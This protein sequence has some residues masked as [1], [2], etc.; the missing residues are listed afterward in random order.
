VQHRGAAER[1]PERLVGT[2]ADP[3]EVVG[4]QRVGE[5]VRPERAGAVAAGGVEQPGARDA[6]R[7][8]PGSREVLT[9]PVRDDGDRV[10]AAD[11]VAL[12]LP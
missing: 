6:G 8:Q 7:E 5:R 1:R 4:E 10:A 3:V 12:E 11:R 2:L 9:E